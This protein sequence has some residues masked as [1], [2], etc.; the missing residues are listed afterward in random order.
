MRTILPAAAFGL[1]LS[2]CQ[3]GQCPGFLSIF[4]CASQ[5]TAAVDVDPSIRFPP[6]YAQTPQRVGR[7][8]GTY[9]LNGAVF[10]AIQVAANDFLPPGTK[11]PPCWKTQAAHTYRVI[12]QGDILF[13]RIDE[14]PAY[15]GLKIAAMHSGAQYAIGLDGRILRRVLDGQPL[16]PFE[17]EATDGGQGKEPGQPGVLPGYEEPE[18]GGAHPPTPWPTTD[19]GPLAP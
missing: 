4:G 11:N 13:V 5:T 14:D 7:D 3:H 19:G 12:R 9:E 8:E 10:R 2:G 16:E 18:D 17:L 15:C 1:L 6:F